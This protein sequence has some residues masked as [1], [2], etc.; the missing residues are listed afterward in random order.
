MA[1]DSQTPWRD[2]RE[3]QNPDQRHKYKEGLLGFLAGLAFLAVAYLPSTHLNPRLKL[4]LM[5]SLAL[6]LGGMLTVGMQI[7]RSYDQCGDRTELI[8]AGL[9]RYVIT[10]AALALAGFAAYRYFWH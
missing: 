2:Q 1:S 8:A 4:M 5:T 3:P 10:M 9:R 7:L 6:L